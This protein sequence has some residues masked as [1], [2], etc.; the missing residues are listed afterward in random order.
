MKIKRNIGRVAADSYGCG[1]CIVEGE[2]YGEEEDCEEAN[3]SQ[4]SI[5]SPI[6]SVGSVSLA[7]GR[8]I[9]LLWI[10]VGERV[11]CVARMMRPS[12]IEPLG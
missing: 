12:K 3:M 6:S 4:V 1:V 8:S 11:A 7:C 5:T 9:A 2:G 10:C